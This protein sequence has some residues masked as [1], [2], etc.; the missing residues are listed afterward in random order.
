MIILD[1]LNQAA[2]LFDLLHIVGKCRAGRVDRLTD[3]PCRICPP[4]IKLTNLLFAQR[5]LLVT[6]ATRPTTSIKSVAGS[7]TAVELAERATPAP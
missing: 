4:G 3:R 6:P 2:S 7:G 1:R 5:T